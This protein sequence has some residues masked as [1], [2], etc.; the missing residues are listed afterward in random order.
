MFLLTV[1]DALRHEWGPG[2][3]G[4]VKLRSILFK[5]GGRLCRAVV[6]ARVGFRMIALLAL[7]AC[8]CLLGFRGLIFSGARIEEKWPKPEPK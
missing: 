3:W 7:S 5:R 6:L 2:G 4:V 8:L 1:G